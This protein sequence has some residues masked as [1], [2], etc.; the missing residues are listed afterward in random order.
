MTALH[1]DP[2]LIAI[3]QQKLNEVNKQLEQT[4]RAKET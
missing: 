2:K 4:K 1:I 3:E